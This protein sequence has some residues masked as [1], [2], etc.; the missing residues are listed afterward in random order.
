MSHKT[1]DIVIV[2]GGF[3]GILA[4]NILAEHDLNVLIVDENIHLGGQYLRS[5]PAQF[6]AI[7]TFS[8]LKRFG[9]QSI[10]AL[11][12]KRIHI[13]TSTEVLGI[14]NKRELLICEAGRRLYTVRPEVVLLATGAREK[15]VPFKGWTLPGVISTGAVQI[16][17]KGS[18]VLP[19]EDILIGGAGI[20]PYAVA[21]EV[22]TKNGRVRAVLDQNRLSEKIA[23]TAGLLLERSKIGDGLRTMTKLALSRTPVKFSVKIIEA[24]GQK[25]LEEVLTVKIDTYGRVLPG[26][27]TV[28]PC[29]CLAI[30]YGFAANIELAQLAGCKLEYKAQQGGWTVGVT[31]DLETAVAGIFAAGEIT[32]IAGAAKS[33][34]EGKLAALAILKKL[35]KISNDTYFARSQKLKNARKKHLRFGAYFNAQHKIPDEINRS[36]ADETIICRCED[37]TMGEIK[38][39]VLNGCATPDA[40]KKAVRTGMGIC[41]GRTCGPIIYE[42][43]AALKGTPVDQIAPLSART[44]LKAVSMKALADPISKL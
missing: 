27:E 22:L 23:F 43:I 30:G 21:A 38:T 4:A 37:I 5:H 34:T 39:A 8:R 9:T 41:Q 20:F 6:G 14:T 7:D 1:Y 16:L 25:G 18:G 17:L 44:P 15:F 12:E 32:G 2:G 28:Y 3:C 40:V 36:I 29:E 26:S 35:G 31:Q 42:I 33:I 11:D 10:K 19:S 13:M 24:C